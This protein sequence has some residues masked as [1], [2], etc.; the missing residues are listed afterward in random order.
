LTAIFLV[1]SRSG[2]L[3]AYKR[4][5]PEGLPNW[6][7][8]VTRQANTVANWQENN[9]RISRGN[10]VTRYS[11]AHLARLRRDATKGR[12]VVDVQCTVRR[13]VTKW[14]A[15]ETSAAWETDTN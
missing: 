15:I 2:G 10:I 4:E 7:L 14:L 13:F 11:T 3:E 12:D 5:E 8:T 1:K 9:L 6:F